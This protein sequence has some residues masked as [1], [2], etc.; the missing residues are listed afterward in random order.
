MDLSPF[1]L[2]R[3]GRACETGAANVRRLNTR[4]N[5]ACYS[6]GHW[7]ASIPHQRDTKD[8]EYEVPPRP[9]K[10]RE[11]RERMHLVLDVVDARKLM[12]V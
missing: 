5:A 9:T 3:D 1:R 2:V 8:L 4:N 7:I 12:Q 6:E 10:T 11:I